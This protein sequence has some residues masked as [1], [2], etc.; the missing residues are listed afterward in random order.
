MGLLLSPLPDIIFEKTFVEGVIPD[1]FTVRNPY[2]LTK[3]IAQKNMSA[4]IPTCQ[5]TYQANS[6]SGYTDYPEYT[7]EKLNSIPVEETNIGG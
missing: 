3:T 2:Q 1:K 4:L 6:T 5:G 7:Y